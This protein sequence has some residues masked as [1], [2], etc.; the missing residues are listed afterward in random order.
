MLFANHSDPESQD[1]A[2]LEATIEAARDQFNNG[3]EENEN[4]P[5]DMRDDLKAAASD[6]F[7][8]FVATA[9]TGQMDSAAALHA[10]AES[11]TLVAGALV[12]DPAKVESGLK[13]LEAT[14]KQK[15]AEFSGIQWNADNHAGVKLHTFT[16][17]V[18]KEHAGPHKLLGDEVKIAVGIGPEAVYLAAGDNYLDALKKAIDAS[19]ANKGKQVPPFQLAISLGPVAE[20]MASQAED[21]PERATAQAMA[22]LIRTEAQGID[23]IRI[24]G[25]VIPNGLRYRFEA[26]QGVLKALGKAAAEQQR[27]AQQAF[28]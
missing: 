11:L 21:G 14:A 27:Q 6:W 10:S 9:K 2:Q 12:K 1:V 16:M 23:H 24:T 5:A 18:P 4:I 7:D 25:N 22:D 26:E 8:A 19:A 15:H 28:Q 20:V 3:L 17:P 13:K